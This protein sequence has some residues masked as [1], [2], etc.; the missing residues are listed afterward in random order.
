MSAPGWFGKIP[1]LG[2][3]STRRLPR[4]FVE[5]W[6]RWLSQE[7]AAAQ[8][9][10]GDAWP[11]HYRRAAIVCF[12]VSAGAVDEHAWHG[13][14]VPSFDR[15]GREF[16]LTITRSHTQIP[17]RPWWAAMAA[18]GQRVLEPGFGAS[19]LDAALAAIR[20]DTPS[21]CTGV[22][23]RNSAWWRWPDEPARA[24]ICDE[25]PSG[26]VFCELFGL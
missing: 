21:E 17:S 2:D 19:E 18:I 7:L 8:T 16:P 13:I 3:F 1:A 26:A 12:A 22:V 5:P 23:A 14:L 15:V 24:V 4:S 6:D 25:L 9:R 11:A 10:L 20:D